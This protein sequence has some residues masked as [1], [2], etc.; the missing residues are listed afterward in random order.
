MKV[1][2]AIG[3]GVFE[4]VYEECVAHELRKAGLS[5]RRQVTLPLTYD[6]VVLPRAFSADVIV[7]NAVLVELKTVEK[8]LPIHGAQLLTYLRLSGMEKGLLIN[9]NTIRLKDGIRSVLNRRG[10]QPDAFPQ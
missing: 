6:G 3:P 9:F 4:S 2:S 1:H 7:E 5:F 8:L 10:T